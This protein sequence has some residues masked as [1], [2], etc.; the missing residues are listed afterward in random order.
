MFWKLLYKTR[1]GSKLTKAGALEEQRL[2]VLVKELGLVEVYSS[3]DE[4]DLQETREKSQLT[5]STLIIGL[6]KSR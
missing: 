6:L 2:G 4:I 3:N 5:T 1:F